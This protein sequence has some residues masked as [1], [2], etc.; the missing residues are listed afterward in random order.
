MNN[1]I[2]NCPTQLH[3]VGHFYKICSMM[4]GS[5]KVKSSRKIEIIFASIYLHISIIFM[6]GIYTCDAYGRIVRFGQL[7]KYETL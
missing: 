1:G 2:I 7:S 3:L 4:H 5:M 6:T